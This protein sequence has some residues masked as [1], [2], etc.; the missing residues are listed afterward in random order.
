MPKPPSVRVALF[1]SALF[2]LAAPPAGLFG[3]APG[4]PLKIRVLL[5]NGNNGKLIKGAGADI[6][7]GPL[8]PLTPRIWNAGRFVGG[9]AYAGMDPVR[10]GADG[11]ILFTVA[12]PAG[13]V[14]V[15]PDPPFAW[16]PCE[17][18]APISGLAYNVANVAAH[19]VVNDN[20]CGKARAVPQPRTIVIFIR[21]ATFWEKL[22]R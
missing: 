14:A 2:T 4:G 20:T 21:P 9:E 3:Q 7:V 8:K 6:W 16:M 10:A 22:K 5:I 13:W 15:H 19:G 12:T 17:V 18:A 11:A 1:L